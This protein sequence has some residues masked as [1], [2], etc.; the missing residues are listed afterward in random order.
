MIAITAAASRYTLRQLPSADSVPATV[1]AS[2][3]PS[4]RPLIN[5]PTTR[6]RSSG[7]ARVAANGTNTWATTENIPASAV[8]S[9]S[10]AKLGAS[11]LSNRPPATTR[12]MPTISPR[13]SSK[14]PSGTSRIRPTA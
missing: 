2:R 5:V 13:R 11:A 1:R 10:T 3:M 4:S 9:S 8:P 12:A 6:P 14:S 7:A